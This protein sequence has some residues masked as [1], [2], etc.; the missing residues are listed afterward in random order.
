MDKQ[1][2]RMELAESGVG[3]PG[4]R[5]AS[6]GLLA[7]FYISDTPKVK[8]Y[9]GPLPEG[10]KGFEFTTDSVPDKGGHPFQPTWSGN[11]PGVRT[12]NGQAVI[13]CTVTAG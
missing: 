9:K 10:E 11:R 6:S 8:A 4:F 13:P 2:A 7:N 1:V 12:E 5:F 3:C